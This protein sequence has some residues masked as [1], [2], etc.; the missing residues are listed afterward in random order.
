VDFTDADVAANLDW[1]KADIK[2]E[3]FTSQFG[4]GEGLQVRAETDPEIN[5]AVT[6]L[7]EAMALEDRDKSLQKTASLH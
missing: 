4:Q 3:L 1:I 7:P 5:K 2:A 6:Y